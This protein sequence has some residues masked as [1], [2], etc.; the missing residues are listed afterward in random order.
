MTIESPTQA[1]WEKKEEGGR[2]STN[3]QHT[4]TDHPH[5]PTVL[6]SSRMVFLSS[7]SMHILAFILPSLLFFNPLYRTIDKVAADKCG[8]RMSDTTRVDA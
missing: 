7:S 6:S 8:G 1:I 4:E 2:E 5:I 3:D